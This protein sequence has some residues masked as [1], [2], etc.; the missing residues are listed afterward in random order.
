MKTNL[1]HLSRIYQDCAKGGADG[2]PCVD[3][4]RLARCAMGDMSRRE[5]DEIVG[6]A[7]DCSACAAALKRLLSLSAEADRAAADLGA[8]LG[9]RKAERARARAAFWRRPAFVPVAAV[10]AGLLLFATS[11]L[12]VPGFMGRSGTR[13]ADEAGVALV[14]PVGAKV[15]AGNGVVLKWE[16]VA[17]AAFYTVEVFDGSMSL[18]WRSGRTAGAE[19]RLPVETVRKMAPGETYYWR[20]TAL[21]ENR[22][23]TRSKL[24]EFSVAR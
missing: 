21:A 2:A 8:V 16:G 23:E 24:A 9:R 4:E 1:A 14:S 13:G 11:I 7:A 10:S 3:P 17:G 6:H 15:S 20:V 12:F 5:R 19:A 18:L 22:R